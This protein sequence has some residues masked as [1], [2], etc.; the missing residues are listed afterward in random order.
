MTRIA[1]VGAS[2]YAGGEMAR[3]VDAHPHWELGTLTAASNEG[4]G[5]TDVHPH[6]R[7]LH[8]RTFAGI[9]LSDLASH[10]VIVLALPHG[11]SGALGQQLA[12]VAPETVLV[13]LG[14]DRRLV[15]RAAW[16]TYYGGDYHDAWVYGMPELVLAD[17]G[18]QRAKLAGATRIVAPG[19]NATAVTLAL[20][21]LIRA[22][23][24]EST[25]VVSTLSVAPSGAGRALREDLLASERL[26]SAQAYAVGG[27]HRH[28]PEVAQNWALAGASDVSLSLT[29]V[30][31]PMSRGILAV[32]TAK[33]SGHPSDGDLREAL[34]SA[35]ANEPF[36]D[37]VPAGVM[38]STGSVMGSNTVALGLATDQATGRV[39]VV[40][41]VDNLY[42]GTAG[43][44]V[45]SLNIAMGLEE[46]TGL[47]TNGVAP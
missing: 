45:Q 30:L 34:E 7:S 2:G 41:A 19:C 12:E 3:L 35:Y 4:R 14:A 46:T 9:D 43:A 22:G 25:D 47:A 18:S 1:I 8:G 16:E 5:V 27:S 44:A 26:G 13:D 31:V 10:D 23:L 32:N 38:P 40:S 21:P 15:N 33:T 36:V 29:P 11:H 17:G 28:I 37:V 24:I 6:L 39:S 42:K 20:A